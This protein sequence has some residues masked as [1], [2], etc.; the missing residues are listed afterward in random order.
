[1]TNLQLKRWLVPEAER[2]GLLVFSLHHHDEEDSAF[3]PAAEPAHSPIID[4]IAQ[5]RRLAKP[6]E[7][8]LNVHGALPH[9]SM[10]R[11]GRTATLIARDMGC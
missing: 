10:A 11:L 5:R 3:V 2:L 7:L 9:A 6:K 8:G 1:M 4:M